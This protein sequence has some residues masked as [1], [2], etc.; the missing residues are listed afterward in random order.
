MFGIN[1]FFLMDNSR[2]NKFGLLNGSLHGIL[3][4]FPG[5]L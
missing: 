2:K 4:S 5:L 3:N 1:N